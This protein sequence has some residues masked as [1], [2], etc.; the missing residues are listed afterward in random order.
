MGV[1][2]RQIMTYE[3]KINSI[4]KRKRRLRWADGRAEE[5]TAKELKGDVRCGDTESL[6]PFG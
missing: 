3:P 6:P 2:G 1:W 4:N 5:E